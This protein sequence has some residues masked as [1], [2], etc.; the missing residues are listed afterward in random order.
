MIDNI[1]KKLNKITKIFF[2]LFILIQY[3]LE[4]VKDKALQYKIYKKLLM[5]QSKTNLWKKIYTLMHRI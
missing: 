5:N 1:N 3:T 2:K 4:F